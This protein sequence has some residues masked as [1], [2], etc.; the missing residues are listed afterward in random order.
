M[1]LW[2]TTRRSSFPVGNRTRPNIPVRSAPPAGRSTLTV[3]V[4]L[5]G[6]PCGATSETVPRGSLSAGRRAHTRPA[7]GAALEGAEVGLRH[8]GL[9]AVSPRVLQDHDGHPRDGHRTGSGPFPRDHAPAGR[10][11]A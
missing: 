6:S 10:P 1:A 3:N 5:S 7:A 11:D 2:G 8:G 4:R 9:E